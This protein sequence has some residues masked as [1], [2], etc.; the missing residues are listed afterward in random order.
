[1]GSQGTDTAEATRILGEGRTGPRS[2]TD[3]ESSLCTAPKVGQ[4]TSGLP[5]PGLPAISSRFAS[6]GRSVAGDL[7]LCVSVHSEL[8]RLT[9]HG[10]EGD[11]QHR[12]PK[13]SSP[14]ISANIIQHP[15][16]TGGREG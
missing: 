4:G 14:A 9:R 16:T 12:L 7:G 11:L 2:P 13:V 8:W 15:L 1:M 10:R 5:P 3:T 6:R